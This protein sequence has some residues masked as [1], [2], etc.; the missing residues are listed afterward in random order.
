VI[1]MVDHLIISNNSICF[2]KPVS[3]TKP[4]LSPW[5]GRVVTT[6]LTLGRH[7]KEEVRDKKQNVYRHKDPTRPEYPIDREYN[8]DE[9]HYFPRMRIPVKEILVEL[10][11]LIKNARK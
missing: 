6:F 3:T 9:E 4:D 11:I 8:C 7:E 10:T 1:A 2:Y 5:T